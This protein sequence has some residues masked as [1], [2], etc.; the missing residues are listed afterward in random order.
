M[1]RSYRRGGE[2]VHAVQHLSLAVE[3]GEF[4][5]VT[6]RSGSGKSTL[7]HLLGGLDVPTSGRV[8]LEGRDTSRLS[9]RERVTL[10]RT[11]VGFV[12][13][14]FFLIPHLTA[15]ENVALPLHYAGVGRRERQARARDLLA[16]M[17]LAGRL[18]HRP[19]QLSGGEAQRVALARAVVTRPR[20]LLADEPTGELDTQTAVALTDVLLA[21]QQASPQMAVVVVTHDESLAQHATRRLHLVDGQFEG[22]VTT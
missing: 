9:E 17:G 15:L 3:A 11:G 21:T 12:F 6:G 16:Q 4:L 5:V 19:D 8:L 22:G 7:L 14:A 13:Q 10:R 20:L 1:C 18:E 2:T